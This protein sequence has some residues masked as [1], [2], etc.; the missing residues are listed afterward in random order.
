[1]LADK[2]ISTINI[3]LKTMLAITLGETN[4]AI[5][6]RKDIVEAIKNFNEYIKSC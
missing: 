5:K 3:C 1:M 2:D 6:A 4:G